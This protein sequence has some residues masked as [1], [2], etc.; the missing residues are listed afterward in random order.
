VAAVSI[1]FPLVFQIIHDLN[2]NPLPVYLTLAFAASAA[3]I[4][5]VSYQTNL[6]VYG[7]GNYKF[8]DFLRI[9]LPFTLIYGAVVILFMLNFYEING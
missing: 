2:L 7:P 5:P 6:M 4:T 8:K 9:G 3:F 1:L